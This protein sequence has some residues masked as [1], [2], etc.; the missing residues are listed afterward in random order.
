MHLPPP[1]IF[2]NIFDECVL[3]I[4]SNQFDSNDP[5]TISPHKSKMCEKNASY[6]VKD[7]EL[8]AKK[9]NKICLIKNCSKS[10]KMAITAI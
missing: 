5:Y 3:S 4:I 10:T 6:L 9:V 1:A 8:G 2:N 7:S